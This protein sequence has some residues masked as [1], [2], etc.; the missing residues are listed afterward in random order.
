MRNQILW[1]GRPTALVRP[2][3]IG[4]SRV[5]TADRLGPYD[6]KISPR[7]PQP[8]TPQ[9]PPAR[10][11]MGEGRPLHRRRRRHRHSLRLPREGPFVATILFSASKIGM[12]PDFPWS[13]A[14]R[15]LPLVVSSGASAGGVD[16]GRSPS[17]RRC[18][19]PH[20]SPLRSL[21]LSML[22]AR[23]RQ[24]TPSNHPCIKVQGDSC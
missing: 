3:G 9:P 24:C 19:P 8:S 16:P 22:L 7:D 11:Q 21:S 12:A 17:P 1:R 13:S 18:P 4:R 14:G 23:C 6:R 2:F 15:S 20:L 10:K 5:S